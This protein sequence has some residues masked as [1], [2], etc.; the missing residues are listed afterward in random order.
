MIIQLNSKPMTITTKPKQTVLLLLLGLFFLCIR[1]DFTSAQE[2]PDIFLS[3]PMGYPA[4]YAKDSPEDAYV[5][6]LACFMQIAARVQLVRSA[7][8]MDKISELFIE[9]ANL[10]PDPCAREY[11]NAMSVQVKW[12]SFAPLSPPWT[13]LEQNKAEILFFPQTQEKTGPVDSVI[14]VNDHAETFKYR[15]YT[16]RYLLMQNN[17]PY[18]T[19]PSVPVSGFAPQLKLADL[20][21]SSF[22][23]TTSLVYPGPEAFYSAEY[24]TFK[25]VIFKNMVEAYVE[26]ILTP[27]AAKIIDA[28]VP[29]P[30]D[31]GSYLAILVLHKI[32]HQLGPV[33]EVKTMTTA[34]TAP[35]MQTKD[36][37]TEPT[38]GKRG[39]KPK[40]KLVLASEFIGPLFPVAEELKTQVLAIHNVS[41]LMDEGLISQAEQ[42]SIYTAYVVGLVDKIRREPFG[43]AGKAEVIQ[44]NYLMKSGVIGFSLT[45]QK[46][47]IQA[48]LF[49]ITIKALAKRVLDTYSYPSIII[50]EYGQLGP[51]LNMLINHLHD[52]PY[53]FQLDW[54][55]QRMRTKQK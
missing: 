52:I 50:K 1:P 16:K 30:V 3:V 43:E 29:Q 25:V 21:Y 11:L 8:A 38:R 5:G 2:G 51:E 17:L 15:E 53:T 9:A 13:E 47:F 22:P 46:L 48:A 32:T 14:Y 34:T 20:V 54:Q 7:K 4:V 19:R 18:S 10:E 42:T 40:Q 35:N 45:S 39:E 6:Q 37:A 36:K 12:N 31:A 28:P 33:L 24:N 41:L 49:P 27:I 55:L 26:C 44:F 23:F